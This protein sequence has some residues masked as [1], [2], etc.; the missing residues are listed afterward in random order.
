VAAIGYGY[1]SE[2]HLLQHLGR[3]RAS[4]TRGIESLTGCTNIDWLDHDEYIDP[5]TKSLKL[6]ELRGVE[7][8]AL[9]D[10]I[11]QEWE[12]LWPQSGNVHNWDAVGRATM[13]G[14]RSWIL[15]EAKAHVGELASSCSATSDDS[16][17]RIR[18][19]L[20]QTRTD[21][22][23]SGDSDWSRDYYQYCNRLTLLHFLQTRGI[24]A[25]MVFVYFVGDRADLGTQ[26]RE[27]PMDETGWEA[28]LEK[29]ARHIGLPDNAKIT[30]A[31]HRLFLTAYRADVAEQILK[32]EY[33][34]APN[35]ARPVTAAA[36]RPAAALAATTR[37]FDEAM[38]QI[39]VRA[40]EEV[41]Y[42][43]T[44]FHQMLTTHGG[45]ETARRLLPQMSDGFT[46]L[47]QEKRLDLTVESL[48]LEQKWH[49]LFSD[50]ER[51]VARR[52][53]RECGAAI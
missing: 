27:C 38:M 53:L 37:A 1:G 19:V 28:A 50:D 49:E 4:F 29:Q 5:A 25:H 42:T 44:R 43:A 35:V 46:R 17:R 8:L 26:G 51:E 31:I 20:S 10:P 3:R 30:S 11:R 23:A 2:W 14:G 48:I 16:L 15:L 32:P 22:G 52:R 21:L 18:Q 12:R 13:S 9:N 45:I 7:F 33:S 47:W 40:K 34:R 6:R 39:Y 24:D 36:P 41:G